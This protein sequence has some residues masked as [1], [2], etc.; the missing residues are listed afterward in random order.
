MSAKERLKSWRPERFGVGFMGWVVCQATATAAEYTVFYPVVQVTVATFMLTP[1][2]QG[3]KE[4][5]VF[6]ILVTVVL[7]VFIA[8]LESASSF[9]SCRYWQPSWEPPAFPWA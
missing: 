2:R 9:R 4:R 1:G 6:R 3:R 5:F 7:A 8:L